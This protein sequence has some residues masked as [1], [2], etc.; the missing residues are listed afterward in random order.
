MSHQDDYHHGWRAP[1]S[2][3]RSTIYDRPEEKQ[4][5]H[6]EHVRL[7]N[8]VEDEIMVKCKLC[9]ERLDGPCPPKE[10]PPEA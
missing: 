3:K 4:C 10:K 9:G 1:M 7:Y 8:I 2:D 5:F 6:L